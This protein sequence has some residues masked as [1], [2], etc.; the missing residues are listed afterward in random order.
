MIS[1][2]TRL[3]SVHIHV[4]TSVGVHMHTRPVYTHMHRSTCIDVKIQACLTHALIRRRACTNAPLHARHVQIRTCSHTRRCARTGALV[5]VRNTHMH[6]HVCT[7]MGMHMHAGST[8]THAQACMHGCAHSRTRN[9]HTHAN[10]LVCTFTHAACRH[11]RAGVQA[12]VC[13]FTH[14][15]I[16]MCARTDAPRTHA[17]RIYTRTCQHVRVHTYTYTARTLPYVHTRHG[18]TEIS[19]T[20]KA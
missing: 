7:C 15:R 19:C 20:K 5:H 10:K 8:H 4:W 18:K 12:C 14:S 17:T 13:T 9:A 1:V 16:R 2:L 11:I 3:T 6:V